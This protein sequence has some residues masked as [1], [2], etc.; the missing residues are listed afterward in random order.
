MTSHRP[1]QRITLPGD[2]EDLVVGGAENELEPPRSEIRRLVPLTAVPWLIVTHEQLLG[3][4]LDSRAAFIL[5][6]IDGRCTVEMVLDMASMDE[7]EAIDILG[8]LLRLRVIELH[9]A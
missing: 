5:S 6:L 1:S 4:P 8:N 2:L 7:D 9:D 3:L